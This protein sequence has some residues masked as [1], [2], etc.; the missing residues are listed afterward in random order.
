MSFNAAKCSVMKMSTKQDPPDRNYIFCGQS[1][2]EVSNHPY[3]GVEL[4]NNL[5]WDIQYK[6]LASKANRVLGFL[7]RNLW[8]CTK[9]IKETAYKTLVR[10]I[11]EYAS[12]SWDPFRKG[13]VISIEAVQ[14]RAARFCMNDYGQQSS[15]TKMTKELGW[16][17]LEVRRR[18]ARLQ[19]M[20]KIMNGDVGINADDYIHT[21]RGGR[22]T[23]G[24]SRRIQR[25]LVKKEVHKNSFFHR[26][27]ADWNRLNEETVT[28]TTSTI[29]KQRLQGLQAEGNTS[30]EGTATTSA[31]SKQRPQGTQAEGNTSEEG[32]ATTSA[33]FKQRLQR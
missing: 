32:T 20:Y 2:K 33:I 4:D 7:K 29:F 31:I 23:R 24:N 21:I 14:R 28:A 8:F 22:R 30:E 16:N 6:K 18:D 17:S 13:D 3:L 26:T 27:A 15:V 9:T 25:E 10:P 5:R 1:L 19:L 11:L 12:S